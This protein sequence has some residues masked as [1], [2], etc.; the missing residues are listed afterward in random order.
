MFST[1]FVVNWISKTFVLALHSF[2]AIGQKRRSRK[3][4]SRFFKFGCWPRSSLYKKKDFTNRCRIQFWI[5]WN[6]FGIE[7]IVCPFLFA[8]CRY[9]HNLIEIQFFRNSGHF[10]WSK[11]FI[12]SR[13]EAKKK[14]KKIAGS[15]KKAFKIISKGK[16]LEGK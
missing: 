12:S 9:R 16:F 8:F 13:E 4:L 11:S 10:R 3:S 7:K 5:D 6:Q 1:H 15:D 14:N 2:S